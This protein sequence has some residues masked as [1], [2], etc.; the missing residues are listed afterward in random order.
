MN[1]AD[2]RARMRAARGNITPQARA[3][4]AAQLVEFSQKVPCLLQARC[5]LG[6]M[7][8]PGEADILALMMELHRRGVHILLPVVEG[9]QL[10]LRRWAPDMPMKAGAYGIYEPGPDAPP[11]RLQQA[12]VA[13]VPGLAFDHGFNRL[14]QGGGYYDRMLS[15]GCRAVLLGVG[16]PFQ[17]VEAL[18]HLPHDHR[19][20]GVLTGPDGFCRMACRGCPCMIH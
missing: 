20:D 14:G 11:G 17:R 19:V 15:D 12:D 13:L 3:Q 5:V 18:P 1:K 7:P 6:Y 10:I 4:H 8:M 9:K 16:Y 2:L